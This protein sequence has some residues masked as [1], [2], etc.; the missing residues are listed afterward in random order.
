MAKV[1]RVV[2]ERMVE[3]LAEALKGSS[4]VLIASM[5]PLKAAETDSLR[6]RLRGSQARMFVAKRTL[7]ERSLDALSAGDRLATLLSGSV[8]FVIPGEDVVKTAKI[9]VEFAKANEG[10]LT[11]R[12]G[13]VEGQILNNK[14]V[15]E[16]ASLPSKPQLIA[17]LVGA[18]ESPFT[19]LIWTLEH[20]MSDLA[21]V[22]EE[23]AKTKPAKA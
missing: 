17:N 13:L 3:E 1:G 18:L 11:V 19:S 14:S 15:E 22:V 16:I 4:S 7:G 9:V 2:K 6:K 8:A 10:K 20:H 5:G 23:A 12:G 21:W